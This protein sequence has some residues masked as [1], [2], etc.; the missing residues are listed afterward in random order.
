MIVINSIIFKLNT[1]QQDEANRIWAIE[2]SL[3]RRQ[4]AIVHS[5]NMYITKPN[6]YRSID[7]PKY[8]QP[9]QPE[10]STVLQEMYIHHNKTVVSKMLGL[11]QGKTPTR[12]LNRWEAGEVEIPY[13]AWRMLLVLSGNAIQTDRIPNEDSNPWV[14][15]YKQ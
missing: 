15:S 6:S 1:N 9:T 7:G 10:I 3:C 14:N 2:E 5:V 11:K 8:Q 12:T 4:C 13:T